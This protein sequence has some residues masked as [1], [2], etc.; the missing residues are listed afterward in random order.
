[1][2]TLLL[3]LLGGDWVLSRSRPVLLHK[4]MMLCLNP[5]H[6]CTHRAILCCA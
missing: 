3:S 1:M 2:L 5:G 6:A 4:V